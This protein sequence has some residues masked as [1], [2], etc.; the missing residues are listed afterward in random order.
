MDS[1]AYHDAAFIYILLMC[2]D[3][4]AVLES[5]ELEG[6]PTYPDEGWDRALGNEAR[7][8]GW[9]IE[10]SGDSFLVLCPDCAKRRPK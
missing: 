8:R 5:E 7:E 1:D 9:R 6:Q 10:D 4:P 3:C 2:D